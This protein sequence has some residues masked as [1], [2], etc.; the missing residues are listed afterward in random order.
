MNVRQD[1]SRRKFGSHWWEASIRPPKTK[2]L[3]KVKGVLGVRKI[4]LLLWVLPHKKAMWYWRWQVISHPQ[5]FNFLVP[6]VK[7]LND[8]PLASSTSKLWFWIWIENSLSIV[9][10]M[11][12]QAEPL[13]GLWFPLKTILHN[14][15]S[16]R[17]QSLWTD[18]MF[19]F[20][21]NFLRLA[22]EGHFLIKVKA[23]K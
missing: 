12:T 18:S 23:P 14:I 1:Y 17:T 4:G 6:K 22:E 8:I 16:S 7:N 15:A 13:A 19:L 21:A 5:V 2:G 20:G 11:R 9:T 3:C 10:H